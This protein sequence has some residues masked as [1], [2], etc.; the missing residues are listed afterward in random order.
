MTERIGLAGDWHGNTSWAQA[1]IRRLA[2]EH[3]V[4]TLLHAGDFGVWPGAAG[5]AYLDAVEDTCAQFDVRLLVT[6]GNHEH[7]RH[8]NRL[9]IEV[10][11]TIGRVTWFTKHIAVLPRGH[12]FTL[13]GRSFVSLGGAPSVDFQSRSQGHDWWPE[14]A[15][16]QAEAEAV[17][18]AGPADIM[19]TH[20]SPAGPWWAPKV[21]EVC[22][23]NDW[24]W[25]QEALTY[26]AE[27]RRVITT[28]F[29]GVRP[30]LLIH[31]H[32]HLVDETVIERDGHSCRIV[33]LHADGEGGNLALL[34]TERLRVTWLGVARVANAWKRV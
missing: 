22:A 2:L 24:G 20:D 5:E 17:A 7:W 4:T 18:A 8:I 14:E 28:A 29:E 32:Y 31:G 30:S 16:T 10:R 1:S 13:N 21:A 15:I 23:T 12:R 34:D 26:T 25:P 27:G 3:R 33:S 19:L 6:P 11:D 9:P